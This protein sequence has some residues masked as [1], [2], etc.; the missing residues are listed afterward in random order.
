MSLFLRISLIAIF[1][2]SSCLA[3]TGTVTFYSKSISGKSEAAVF[4][5]KSQQ[6]FSGWLSD[7]QE[8]LAHLQHGRFATFHLNPGPH[9]FTVLGP[10]GP[11]KVPLVLNIKD[12]GEYCVRLFA[13]MANLE[14]YGQWENQIEEVPCRQAVSEGAHLKPIRGKDVDPSA[15]DKFDPRTTFPSANQSQH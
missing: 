12:G 8:R 5:P 4:L 1:F 13:K 10:T 2:G 11:G 3:Q 9:S 6:P 14:I 7:G 15:S